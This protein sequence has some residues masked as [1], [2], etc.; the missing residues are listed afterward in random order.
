MKEAYIILGTYK[1][2]KENQWYINKKYTVLWKKLSLKFGHDVTTSQSYKEDRF[3]R[4]EGIDNLYFFDMK[5]FDELL[6]GETKD[7]V[8]F[9][10]CRQEFFNGMN[11]LMDFIR[12]KPDVQFSLGLQ[13]N[14]QVGLLKTYLEEPEKITSASLQ[15]IARS[16]KSI[17]FGEIES[18]RSV[19]LKAFK[20][21][22]LTRPVGFS[23]RNEQLFN[24]TW[25]EFL[26]FRT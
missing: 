19:N 14:N 9:E 25:D 11:F 12:S 22:N 15:S 1:T 16:H 17:G 20:I 3:G 21:Y 24:E 2:R 8:V 7:K 6:N 13:G 18:I 23:P 4:V 10:S 26:N 5:E